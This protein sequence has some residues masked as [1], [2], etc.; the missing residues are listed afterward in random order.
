MILRD[1]H[2]LTEGRGVIITVLLDIKKAH[3]L[4]VGS[5]NSHGMLARLECPLDLT[6]MNWH[7]V[8]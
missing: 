1:R 4:R 5:R 8:E 2:L 6:G 3:F 7:D